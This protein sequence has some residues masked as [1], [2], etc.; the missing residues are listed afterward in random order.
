MIK[1][2]K[3]VILVIISGAIVASVFLM[4]GSLFA[5]NNRER[6]SSCRATL[7]ALDLVAE[8]ATAGIRP[9]PAP[10]DPDNPLTPAFQQQ[11]AATQAENARRKLVVMRA[12]HA[13][14]NLAQS[15][16]CQ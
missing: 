10:L 13:A 12:N 7:T 4:L 8:T 6:L 14:A 1:R 15:D 3:P 11:R 16:F 2:W 5:Q 9:V